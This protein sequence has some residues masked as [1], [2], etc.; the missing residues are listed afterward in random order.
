MSSGIMREGCYRK[1]KTHGGGSGMLTLEGL[2]RPACFSGAFWAATGHTP[3]LGEQG[4]R[5]APLS[6]AEAPFPTH[7][8]W[9]SSAPVDV[10]HKSWHMT[11]LDLIC[12]SHPVKKVRSHSPHIYQLY[13]KQAPHS[14]E[15]WKH[16]KLRPAIR[17]EC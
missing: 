10:S 6:S 9:L 17:F 5:S 2:E 13:Q 3:L 8:F 11:H 1:G 15:C 7:S 4:K 12:L 14:T 16:A